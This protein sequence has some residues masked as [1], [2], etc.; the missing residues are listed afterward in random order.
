[1]EG[2]FQYM[3]SIQRKEFFQKDS[4]CFHILAR[5]STEPSD[6]TIF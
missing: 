1:M 2:V 5:T 3:L 6:E 4:Y